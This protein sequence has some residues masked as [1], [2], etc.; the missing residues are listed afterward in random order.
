MEKENG[1]TAHIG[2]FIEQEQFFWVI[3]S[4]NS[5]RIISD[6][7]FQAITQDT[8]ENTASYQFGPQGDYAQNI[9]YLWRQI[10]NNLQPDNQKAIRSQ[11]VSIEEQLK[12]PNKTDVALKIDGKELFFPKPSTTQ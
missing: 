2:A 5:H 7:T 8:W 11:W 12:D 1:S 6:K 3:G 4:K 10:W 9:I